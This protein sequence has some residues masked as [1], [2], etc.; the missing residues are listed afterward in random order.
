MI[1]TLVNRLSSPSPSRSSRSSSSKSNASSTTSTSSS[2]QNIFTRSRSSNANNFNKFKRSQLANPTNE[3]KL[4]TAPTHNYTKKSF[5][6][7]HIRMSN[8]SPSSMQGSPSHSSALPPIPNGLFST[9]LY[10]TSPRANQ[11]SCLSKPFESMNINAMES[12]NSTAQSIYFSK[13]EAVTQKKAQV[14]AEKLLPTTHR[15]QIAEP[16]FAD[17]PEYRMDHKRRGFAIIINNKIFDSKLEMPKREGTDKDAAS[18]EL[19]L[20]KLGFD[21]RLFHNCTALTMRDLLLRYL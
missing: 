8:S 12:E 19:V 17:E 7:N 15:Q 4:Q 20:T 14:E 1:S 9:K 18:L 16:R 11:E 3:A 21:I 13:N 6:I 5:I 2:S 10:Q